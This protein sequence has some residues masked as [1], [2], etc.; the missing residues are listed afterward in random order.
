[1]FIYILVNELTFIEI[2]F[3]LSIIFRMKL[4]SCTSLYYFLQYILSLY[5]PAF[6]DRY[7]VL[8][9]FLYKI[10][11][12]GRSLW[13]I[14]TIWDG[15]IILIRKYCLCLLNFSRKPC[16]H[17]RKPYLFTKYQ[18]ITNASVRCCHVHRICNRRNCCSCYFPAC[19]AGTPDTRH[20]VQ[21]KLS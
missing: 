4:I 20:L 11:V 2:K 18:Y 5:S 17:I 19:V 12:I 21:L 15:L 6:V 8:A 16:I 3:E 10:I 9:F 14:P 7:C 1:M 13:S